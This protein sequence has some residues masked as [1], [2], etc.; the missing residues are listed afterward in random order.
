MY[1][2]VHSREYRDL[3]ESRTITS[4]YVLYGYAESATRL[5]MPNCNDYIL[6]LPHN[7]QHKSY[8]VSRTKA[9][10]L[11]ARGAARWI[12]GL[13]RIREV[14]LSARGENRVW[15]KTLCYDPADG[16]SVATMQLVVP[17]SRTPR[18]AI[19]KADA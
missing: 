8:Q 18:R 10:Q 14:K 3:V 7:P 2:N 13:K 11:V 12:P 16:T 9:E 15:R 17:Q 6:V 5:L 4:P 1:K 19:A